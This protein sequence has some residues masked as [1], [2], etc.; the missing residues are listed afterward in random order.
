MHGKHGH[1]AIALID[2]TVLLWY[3]KELQTLFFIHCNVPCM[4]CFN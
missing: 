4:L 2:I 1:F 3:R